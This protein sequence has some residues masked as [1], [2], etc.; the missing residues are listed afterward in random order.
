MAKT[1]YPDIRP[2]MTVRIYQRITDVN[3]KGEEKER[4]QMFEGIV[5]ARRGAEPQTTI[6]VRKI[7]E[8]VGVEKI[9]PLA[10]PSI[11][12][13]EIVKQAKV[14]RAKL[15]FLRKSKKTLKETTVKKAR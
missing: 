2:G 1:L 4:S 14:H 15:Y 8:G 3:S 5:L 6:T 10:M 7:S 11:E 13:I 12:K 9:L